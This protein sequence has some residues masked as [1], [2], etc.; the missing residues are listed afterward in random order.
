MT[1]LAEGEEVDVIVRFVH[2]YKAD[3]LVV[4]L[5]QHA[6]HISRLWS[7]VYQVAQDAPCSV[8]GVH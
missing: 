4:G 5:H 3:L 8:L 2:R 6:L 1:D 7:T